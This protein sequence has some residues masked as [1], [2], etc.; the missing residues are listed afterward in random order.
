MTTFKLSKRDALQT[1]IALGIST[2]ESLKKYIGK[3]GVLKG[4]ISNLKESDQEV[5]AHVREVQTRNVLRPIR[6]KKVEDREAMLKSWVTRVKPYDPLTEISKRKA[7]GSSELTTGD[8][9]SLSLKLPQLEIGGKAQ[10]DK[11]RNDKSKFRTLIRMVH[12][13]ELAFRKEDPEKKPLYQLHSMSDL[14]PKRFGSGS[15]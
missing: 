3:L 7:D 15:Q 1:L 5:I 10:A 2:S 4:S 11:L 12:K 14:T 8:F 9:S 6:G 13:R